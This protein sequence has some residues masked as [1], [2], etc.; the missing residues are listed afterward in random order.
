MGKQA[1]SIVRVIKKI[2]FFVNFF[3]IFWIGLFILS[4]FTL[5]SLKYFS[6][7]TIITIFPTLLLLIFI[8][9]GSIK[10]N[11]AAKIVLMAINIIIICFSGYV[12][13]RDIIFYYITNQK[14]IIFIDIT[15]KKMFVF[16][17]FFA[18]INLLSLFNII[19]SFVVQKRK[20]LKAK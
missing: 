14:E 8:I 16:T 7:L 18:A 15:D 9:I 10:D 1:R 12:I 11:K 2:L 13:I 19:A 17:L 6:V 5:V 3:N 4:L 20:E